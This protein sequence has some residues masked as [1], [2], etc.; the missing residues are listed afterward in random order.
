[1]TVMR[2]VHSCYR[3]ATPLR[4]SWLTEAEQAQAD[5]R[6]WSRERCVAA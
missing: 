5:A 2:A 6:H 3:K 4:L 1:L